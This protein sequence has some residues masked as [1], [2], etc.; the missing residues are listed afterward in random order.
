MSVNRKYDKAA[1]LLIVVLVGFF[2]FQPRFRLREDMPS[3]FVSDL[4][5]VPSKQRA[6]EEKIARA[7]WHCAVTQTQW[8]YGYGQRLPESPPAEFNVDPTE[9][10]PESIQTA[11]RERYW[12]HLQHVWYLP[13]AWNK[14]YAW[15]VNAVTSSLDSAGAWL[16]SQLARLTGI[17]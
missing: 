6:A 3:E 10:G 2:A 17:G 9:L 11:T 12:K 13:T 15:D 1:I 16:E 5:S 4:G 14:T 8:T 7:Y